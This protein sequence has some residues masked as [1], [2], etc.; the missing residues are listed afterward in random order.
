MEKSFAEN[1]V[2]TFEQAVEAY[3]NSDPI[4]NG[5]VRT[6]MVKAGQ[7]IVQAL[8]V[9][10]PREMDEDFPDALD[11]AANAALTGI[12]ATEVEHPLSHGE[13]ADQAVKYALA[14]RNRLAAARKEGAK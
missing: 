4:D 8:T 10:S 9:P 12:I 5:R 11:L 13:A 14:L 1:L 7:D 3:I 2:A 6:R